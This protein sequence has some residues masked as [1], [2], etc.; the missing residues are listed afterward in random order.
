MSV[1]SYGFSVFRGRLCFSLHLRL[2][3]G[4]GLCVG[5]CFALALGRRLLGERLPVPGTSAVAG[6]SR[7]T[8]RAANP[9]AMV[10]R[11]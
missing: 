10:Q 8:W 3:V 5:L 11:G 2:R 4:L 1:F 9:S 6:T 7:A